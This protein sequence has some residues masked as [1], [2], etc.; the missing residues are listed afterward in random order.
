[1]FRTTII[2]TFL[3]IVYGFSQTINLTGKIIDS[4][5]LKPIDNAKISIVGFPAISSLSNDS[6]IFILSNSVSTNSDFVFSIV[7]PDVVVCGNSLNIFNV[8]SGVP[9]IVSIYNSKGVCFYFGKPVFQSGITTINSGLWRTPGIYF[10]ELQI[11]TNAYFTKFISGFQ[12]RISLFSANPKTSRS[13]NKSVVTY[14]VRV[15]KSGY[16]SNQFIIS[17]QQ[18]D[19]GIIKLRPIIDSVNYIPLSVGNFIQFQ[20]QDSSTFQWEIVS[21]TKRS[22]SKSVFIETYQTG[23]GTPDSFYL[24]DDGQFLVSC[25]FLDSLTDSSGNNISQNP[26]GEQRL[27]L[28]N[29]TNNQVW[30]QYAEDTSSSYRIAKPYGTFVT[31][32]GSFQNVFGFEL[33]GIK[34]DSLPMMTVCFANNLGWI[35]TLYNNNKDSIMAMPVYLRVEGVENGSL[36]PKR[37]P[38]LAKSIRTSSIWGH[39]LLSGIVHSTKSAYMR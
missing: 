5:S 27:A 22:D 25:D 12:N 10:L 23:N 11:G 21:S 9:I 31:P 17:D 39:I 1:M 14:T 36:I 13:L 35:G 37:D 24:Y 38:P 8:K 32:I 28:K 33:Y 7:T 30:Y 2:M 15:S 6:G 4:S 26:F 29:P 16:F 3:F 20:L 19:A 18:T 34:D